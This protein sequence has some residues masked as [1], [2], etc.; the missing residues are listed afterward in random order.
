MNIQTNDHTAIR[1]SRYWHAIKIGLTFY[2]KIM[3]IPK[4]G[5][6]NNL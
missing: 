1:Y 5:K 2:Y 3:D 6:C 4:F